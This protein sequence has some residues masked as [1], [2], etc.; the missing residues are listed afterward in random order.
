MSGPKPAGERLRRPARHECCAHE[1]RAAARRR[2]VAAFVLTLAFA[3]PGGAAEVAHADPLDVPRGPGPVPE[4]QADLPLLERVNNA[5]EAYGNRGYPELPVLSWALLDAARKNGDAALIER[6]RELS[7]MDAGVRFEAARQTG[8]PADLWA[9]AKAITTRLPG[10]VWLASWLGTTLGVGLLATAALAAAVHFARTIGLHGH[11]LG[12]LVGLREQAAWPGM[13]LIGAGLALLPFAGAGPVLLIGMLGA[14]ALVRLSG[15]EVFSLALVLLLA[16]V[17]LGPPLDGWARLV[18]LHGRDPALLAAWR[19]RQSQPLPG[20]L[21]LLERTLRQEPGR[22]LVRLAL[23]TGWKR[24]GDLDRASSVLAEFPVAPAGLRARAFNQTGI[25]ELARG[26]VREATE[27][28]EKAQSFEETAAVLYNL[29]QAHGRGLRLVE[30]TKVFGAARALD[31]ELVSRYTALEGANVHRYTIDLPA[32]LLAYGRRALAGSAEAEELSTKVR[33]ALLGPDT[34]AWGWMLLPGLVA[35]GIA[36]RRKSIQRCTRCMRSVCAAC[37]GASARGGT[38]QRCTRLCSPDPR[39]DGRTDARM[40]RRQL[41]LDRGRQ[42]VLSR[43]LA[44]LGLFVPGAPGLLEGRGTIGSLQVLATALVP[45]ALV[46]ALTVPASSHVAG[47][48]RSVP[49]I[50]AVA[51]AVPVYVLAWWTAMRR[52]RGRRGAA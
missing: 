36:A 52:L 31:P 43:L 15:K 29:S 4:Q 7:P 40:R 47:V 37:D 45:A 50:A 19:V 34:P 33:H 14:L 49:L 6:A 3:S 35:L 17:A 2:C 39:N 30:Q 28:F 16:G 46:A 25:V 11:A 23:A 41:T 51:V 24:E 42:A 27:A 5:A 8:N 13:L 12:H 48:A 44:A 26:N 9:A 18:S 32:P 22:P 38:C 10:L 20:D 1:R 21:D